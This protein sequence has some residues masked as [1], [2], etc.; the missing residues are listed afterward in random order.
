MKKKQET[1]MK[2]R[3]NICNEVKP[4]TDFHKNPRCPLGYQYNC[5]KCT[6][7]KSKPEFKRC[8]RCK[9]KKPYDS[10]DKHKNT[11]QCQECLKKKYKEYQTRIRR[12]N[13]CNEVKPLTDFHK[14][15]KSALGRT[16]CCIKCHNFQLRQLYQKN[17]SKRINFSPIFL[18]NPKRF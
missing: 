1:I 9:E 8:S 15:S 16:Y 13:K 14:R 7:S 11:T 5:K 3:C 10:F 18:D 4:L 6:F 2:K 17:K 12:C